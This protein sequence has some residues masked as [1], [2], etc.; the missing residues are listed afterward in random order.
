M[1]NAPLRAW[2]GF[3]RRAPPTRPLILHGLAVPEKLP[4]LGSSLSDP[5]RWLVSFVASAG[6]VMRWLVACGLL[7][8]QWGCAPAPAPAPVWQAVPVCHD[9]PVFVGVKNHEFVWET[10]VDVVDD[11][12]EIEREDP[13]RIVGNVPTSGR[14]DTFPI[15]PP[16]LLEPWRA[17]SGDPYTKL[18]NT[19][20]STRRKAVVQ[21]MPDRGGYWVDVAVF[22]YLEDL[23]RPVQASA[24]AATF[25]NDTSLTRVVNPVAEQDLTV[26]W[27]PTG[28]DSALEQQ[29]IQQLL[30]RLGVLPAL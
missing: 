17:D 27:I 21:V 24:G 19:L 14:L 9:N 28:R 26:G 20:Q 1:G 7:L 4:L 3:G 5:I 29:I 18:K 13:V 30:A 25:R 23:D 6:S 2:S 22:T 15:D 16:T 12:F 11:Y 10:L 8:A